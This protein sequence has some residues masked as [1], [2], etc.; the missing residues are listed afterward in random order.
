MKHSILITLPLK[1]R[2]IEKIRTT[3]PDAAV[4]FFP[5]DN[6]VT[7]Y[8]AGSTIY[9]GIPTREELEASPDITL[10]QAGYAGVDAL[11]LDVLQKR[12]TIIASAKGI[13]NTQMS[14]LFFAMVLYCG[15]NMGA[16]A[17]QKI[18]REWNKQPVKDTFFLGGKSLCIV[19]Y[20]TIGKKIAMIA[21]TFDMRVTGVR[22]SVAPEDRLNDPFTDEV[23][24]VDEL[25]DTLSTSDIVL[26]LLPLTSNTQNFFDAKRLGAMKAGS[27][28]VNLG[29]GGT[30]DDEALI[31]ALDNETVRCAALDVFREEPLPE[32]HPF[33]SHPGIIIT[34]HI[35]GLMP[36][37]WGAVVDLFIE[38]LR[39]YINDE[40]LLN[41]V[42]N[43]SGY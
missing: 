14:E 38:N 36:D 20:G 27:M 28:F 16:W 2:H 15:R 6:T 33:W 35:G 29:R 11:P 25:I 32:K 43:E 41:V 42:D 31:N 34:P 21:Q 37:Y 9:L 3:F 40:E 30:V 39:R 18:K 24:P 23:I 10:I 1:E 19:G 26:N 8:H 17:A 13:H 12:E 4:H 22:S 7:E 5:G